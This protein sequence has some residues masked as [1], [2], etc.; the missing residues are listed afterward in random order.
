[1]SKH[2]LDRRWKN[3]QNYFNFHK[4]WILEAL[5]KIRTGQISESETYYSCQEILIKQCKHFDIDINKVL[6]GEISVEEVVDIMYR[7]T[8]R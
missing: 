4:S 8:L 2:K 3:Y 1:M 7:D 6:S 5:N